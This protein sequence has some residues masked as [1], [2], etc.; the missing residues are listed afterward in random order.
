MPGD[1]FMGLFRGRA[2][3][4]APFFLASKT[5][6]YDPVPVSFERAVRKECSVQFFVRCTPRKGT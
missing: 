1:P 5:Y 4:S 2:D 3:G 6:S